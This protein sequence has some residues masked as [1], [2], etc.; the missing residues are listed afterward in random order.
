[1]LAVD[2]RSVHAHVIGE[3]GDSELAAWSCARVAGVP[4]ADFCRDRRAL[5]FDELVERVRRA[6]PDIIDR[7]GYTSYAIATCV[8]RICEAILSDQHTI[9]PVS[10]LLTGQHGIDGVYLSIPCVVG[11][12]GVERI[13]ELPLDD[14]ELAALRHSAEVLRRTRADTGV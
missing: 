3:H 9:L 6:A 8:A 7:K 4:I 5:P 14:A 10:T 2:A 1:L 13:V 12:G 11:R